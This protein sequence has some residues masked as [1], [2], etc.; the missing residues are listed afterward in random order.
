MQPQRT[1]VKICG[2]R[3]PEDAQ[4]AARLGADAIGMVL[5][6]P[7]KRNAPIEIAKQIIAALPAFVTPVG[8]FVDATIDHI[9]K[10]TAELGL[11]HVQLN[12]NE[13]A[14]FIAELSPLRVI[15]AVRVATNFEDTLAGWHT[16]MRK[17]NLN[18]LNGIVLEPGNTGHA[19]GS[20]VANDWE[21]IVRLKT[22]GAFDGLPPLIAAGGLTPVDVGDVVRRVRPYAVDVSSGVEDGVIGEK[23]AKKIEAFIAVVR[24][25]DVI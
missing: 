6:P 1:R 18:H 8:L 22:S 19:G 16:A 5:H 4:A 2:V 10:T 24:A 13:S 14:E 7:A 9:R 11:R 12:G 15:K 21:Q 3:R 23:S 17:F 25:A 20:G